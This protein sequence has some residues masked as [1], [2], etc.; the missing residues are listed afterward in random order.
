MY[1]Y[2]QMNRYYYYIIIFVIFMLIIYYLN[3]NNLIENTIEN[4]IEN[5]DNKDDDILIPDLGNRVYTKEYKE[6]LRKNNIKFIERGVIKKKI[7]NPINELIKVKLDKL[8]D[9]VGLIKHFKKNILD[10]HVNKLKK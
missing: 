4:T 5:M 6:K 3:T 8:N 2:L 1:R 7:I 10:L 9:A